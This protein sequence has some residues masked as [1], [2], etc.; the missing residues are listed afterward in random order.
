[1]KAIHSNFTK[2]GRLRQ[3]VRG[4]CKKTPL[5]EFYFPLKSKR[6]LRRKALRIKYVNYKKLF[7]IKDILYS[8]IKKYKTE[9]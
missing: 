1:V 6:I 8:G 3:I 2:E 9:F 5:L 4:Y 7:L